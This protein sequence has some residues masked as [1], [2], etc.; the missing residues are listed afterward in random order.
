VASYPLF[1]H[2]T[3]L[4]NLRASE[5]VVL[6]EHNMGLDKGTIVGLTFDAQDPNEDVVE[7][8]DTEE[9]RTSAHRWYDI[10][11]VWTPTWTNSAAIA[12]MDEAR[13]KGRQ[14]IDTVMHTER[15]LQM[16]ELEVSATP[17]N[18]P[19]SRLE[20]S[21]KDGKPVHIFTDEHVDD[22][23][24]T[25]TDLTGT[26]AVVQTVQGVV[27]VRYADVRDAITY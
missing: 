4:A 16:Q 9:N 18:Y 25:V 3:L 20:M 17:T 5:T 13:A 7:L 14:Y 6:I 12:R 11:R 15:W 21:L 26:F 10:R 27:H 8:Q 23:Y 1:P 2:R 24:G 22:V 19:F